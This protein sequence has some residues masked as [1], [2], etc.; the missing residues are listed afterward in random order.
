VVKACLLVTLACDK[1]M[2]NLGREI[3]KKTKEVLSLLKEKSDFL[4][5]KS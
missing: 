2:K 5:F 4:L 3:K 1:S